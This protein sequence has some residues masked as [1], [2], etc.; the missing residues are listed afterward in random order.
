M[1]GLREMAQAVALPLQ[2][3]PAFL[4]LLVPVLESLDIEAADKPADEAYPEAFAA[5]ALLAE[6]ALCGA[7]Q[8]AAEGAACIVP[9]PNA[10]PVEI[11]AAKN[12]YVEVVVSAPHLF[13][14]HLPSTVAHKPSRHLG[15]MQT[16]QAYRAIALLFGVSLE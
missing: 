1:L 9:V 7:L 4:R 15:G 12:R 5:A 2:D 10:L 14:P 16:L 8:I 6:A 11:V 13:L 3:Y